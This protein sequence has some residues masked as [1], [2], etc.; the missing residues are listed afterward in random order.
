MTI[1][2]E[3]EKDENSWTSTTAS[4]SEYNSPRNSNKNYHKSSEENDN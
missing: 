4:S 2:V 1:F 3:K